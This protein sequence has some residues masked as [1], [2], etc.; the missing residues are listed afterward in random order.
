MESSDQHLQ[1]LMDLELVDAIESG[2]LD[3]VQAL[4]TAGADIE[5]EDDLGHRPL[6]ASV[7]AENENLEVVRALIAAGADVNV[8]DENGDTALN[9]A[10][11]VGSLEVVQ[12]L[13]ASGADIYIRRII[14]GYTIL[15]SAAL[16]D[17][18]EVAQA[19][20]AAGLD[21][22]ARNENGDKPLDIADKAGNR[23]VAQALRSAGSNPHPQNNL[24]QRAQ[25]STNVGNKTETGG[26]ADST[27]AVR[28]D[29]ATREAY[30]RWRPGPG[31]PVENTAFQWLPTAVLEEGTCVDPARE[32]AILQTKAHSLAASGHISLQVKLTIIGAVLLGLS[33]FLLAM[34]VLS[35]TSV[36]QMGFQVGIAGF[37][38]LFLPGLILL[39][40][41]N[42][43]H[44]PL[45]IRSLE[46]A[47]WTVYLLPFPSGHLQFDANK[48]TST[49]NLV[50]QDIPTTKIQGTVEKMAGDAASSEHEKLF[51]AALA[52]ARE[53]C[54][55]QE[56][57]DFE[58]AAV[59]VDSRYFQDVASL[60][61]SLEPGRLS[62]F[63]AT[64][65]ALSLA[66]ATAQR[67][68]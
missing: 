36:V 31:E 2:T 49:S 65:P 57:V 63:S 42:F 43:I 37:S 35:L 40:Y 5:A 60:A 62:P 25:D 27:G 53:M 46:K 45:Q 33:V 39:V 29:T 14:M 16:G 26:P 13:V 3:R 44:K 12:A 34:L 17:N 22:N 50:Y 47:W 48:L 38:V 54:K 55:M 7:I 66:D 51:L 8:K 61:L 11:M 67:D 24:G 9:A 58:C 64:T 23:E 56:R 15:H 32:M 6:F 28:V 1:E 59:P 30:G 52:S 68:R 4:I 21:P 19:L 18:L 41:G 10:A 20:I